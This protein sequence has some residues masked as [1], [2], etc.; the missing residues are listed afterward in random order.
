MNILYIYILNYNILYVLVCT[1][2]I[3]SER[4]PWIS[5]DGSI[6]ESHP[7]DLLVALRSFR[8]K[9]ELGLLTAAAGGFVG[10]AFDA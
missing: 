1:V 2:L 9:L 7:H 10:R 5:W 4:V 6:N 8:P 3:S